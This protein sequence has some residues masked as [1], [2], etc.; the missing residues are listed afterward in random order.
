MR[1]RK[2]PRLTFIAMTAVI[3]LISASVLFPQI[4][5]TKFHGDESGWIFSAYYYTDLLI[6]RDFDLQ[7]WECESCGPWGALNMHVGKWLI[8]IP[9]LTDAHRACFVCVDLA[10]VS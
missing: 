7:K 4:Q 1:M 3:C 5:S 10:A 6:R 2:N 8:G 9:L